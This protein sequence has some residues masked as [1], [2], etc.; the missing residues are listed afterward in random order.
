[1]VFRARADRTIAAGRVVLASASLFA[2]WLDPTQ[3]K[4]YQGL[5][6]TLLATYTVYALFCAVLAWRSGAPRLRHA[7]VRH[8][9]DLAAFTLFM[10]LTDGPTSPLFPFLIF[11]I[12]AG[13]L[14]WQWKG[15]VWTAVACV[16]ILLSL[17]AA[18][19]IDVTDAEQVTRRVFIRAWTSRDSSDDA[20]VSLS[21]WLVGLTRLEVARAQ[22]ASVAPPTM[23]HTRARS[24]STG[25]RRLTRTVPP[26][27]VRWTM[28]LPAWRRSIR[29]A[30][31]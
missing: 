7:A 5:A 15:T 16:L 26:N 24:T 25:F 30:H 11:A 18:D 3:P 2:I 20:Q 31:R 12:L 10:Y 6:Y 23:S 22:G 1:M 14:H 9:G 21:A 8:V 13:T 4:R 17:A 19:L 28:R 27:C 29:A